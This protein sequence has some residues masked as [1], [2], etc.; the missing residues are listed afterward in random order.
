MDP[1]AVQS[2]RS[3]DLSDHRTDSSSDPQTPSTHVGNRFQ[4]DDCVHP[5]DRFTNG[6]S[7]KHFGLRCALQKSLF[8][9]AGGLG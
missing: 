1:V 7:R 3:I 6:G 5:V 2:N 8:T 9:G 4:S